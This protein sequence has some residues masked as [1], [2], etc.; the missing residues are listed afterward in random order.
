V[1]YNDLRRRENNPEDMEN[2]EFYQKE[3]DGGMPVVHIFF[4]AT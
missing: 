2:E 1:V 3:S 4:Y